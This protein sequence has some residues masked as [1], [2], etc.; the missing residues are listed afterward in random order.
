MKNFFSCRHAK[1]ILCALVLVAVAALSQQVVPAQQGTAGSTAQPPAKKKLYI[2]EIKADGIPEALARSMREQIRLAIFEKYGMQ[3][4]VVSD[5]DIT[6]MYKKA[7]ELMVQNCNA[8]SC[9][10]QI[11]DAIDADEII[12]GTLRRN[13]NQLQ[14]V[15]NNLQR[16]KKSLKNNHQVNC[17]YRVSRKR[18]ELL[19]R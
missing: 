13:G 16:D 19:C 17:Q 1:N 10:T 6:L 2:S 14:L 18:N 5:E 7:Q 3:Y 4:Y 8:E 15:A 9:M 11:A 12:Y